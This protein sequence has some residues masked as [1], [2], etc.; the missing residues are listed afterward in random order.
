MVLGNA[1]DEVT[2]VA[3][4]QRNERSSL[5]PT[6]VFLST[7]CVVQTVGVARNELTA[8][9]TETLPTSETIHCE[10]LLQPISDCHTQFPILVHAHTQATAKVG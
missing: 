9:I 1:D 7:A 10:T 3:H 4:P 5:A 6:S 8:N 2:L